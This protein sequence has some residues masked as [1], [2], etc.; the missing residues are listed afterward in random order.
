[1]SS[2]TRAHVVKRMSVQSKLGLSAVTLTRVQVSPAL[3]I[4][5]QSLSEKPGA[6]GPSR[7]LLKLAS[8]PGS[9]APL[10][11]ASSPPSHGTRW[12]VGLALY[13]V[14]TVE[15]F[16]LLAVCANSSAREPAMSLSTRD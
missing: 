12:L 15:I 3:P 13:C 14:Q 1:M 11:L 6:A 2:V 10:P 9:S 16:K 7:M 8:S 5:V 4:A